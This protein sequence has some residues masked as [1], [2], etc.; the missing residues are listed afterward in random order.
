M[1]DTHTERPGCF[2]VCITWHRMMSAFFFSTSVLQKRVMSEPAAWQRIAAN[3]QTSRAVVCLLVLALARRVQSQA[4]TIAAAG[5][6]DVQPQSDRFAF[7]FQ[8]P[9]QT[10]RLNVPGSLT[11]LPPPSHNCSLHVGDLSK[12]F[13]R[14][15]APTWP[16]DTLWCSYPNADNM[17]RHGVT[18]IKTLRGARKEECHLAMKAFL[19]TLFNRPCNATGGLIKPVCM[20]DCLAAYE[21]C[22]YS[23]PQRNL[24]CSE[25]L[26]AG[27]VTYHGDTHYGLLSRYR[28][29]LALLISP[30][31]HADHKEFHGWHVVSSV[32]CANSDSLGFVM[33]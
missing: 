33:H 27:W 4:A 23:K 2:T 24:Q 1:S 14:R 19:C 3:L 15:G 26:K 21:A 13:C 7:P 22:G 8:Y 20:Y 12:T 9:C 5:A 17:A 31:D 10:P 28:F 6:S 25:F 18:K 32:A 29:P 30:C 11:P 16:A